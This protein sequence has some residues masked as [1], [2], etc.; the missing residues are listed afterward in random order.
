LIELDLI[1]FDR[2]VAVF[3]D[4]IAGSRCD[5]EVLVV[6]REVRLDVEIRCLL[7]SGIGNFEAA[8]LSRCLKTQRSSKY[9]K[10]PHDC[11]NKQSSAVRTN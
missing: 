11:T 7:G 3:H 8:I 9:A 5:T 1:S 2:H 4:D 10:K 6:I